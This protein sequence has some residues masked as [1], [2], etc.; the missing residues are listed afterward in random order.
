[1]R[2]KTPVNKTRPPFAKVGGKPPKPSKTPMTTSQGVV[3]KAKEKYNTGFE[4]ASYVLSRSRGAVGG[5][6]A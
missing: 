5:F 6:F 2:A 3:P 4:R 1:M